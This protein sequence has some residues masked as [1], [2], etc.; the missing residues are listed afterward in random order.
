MGAEEVGMLRALK[1]DREE[2]FDPVL[3]EHH[4]RIVKLTGDG[5]LIEFARA[6]DALSWAASVQQTVAG[7][8]TG[9]AH[10]LSRG[11]RH[12]ETIGS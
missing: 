5:I 9:S 1:A 12:S 6:V 11:H 10:R 2:P 4:G 7:Y 3:A 8:S